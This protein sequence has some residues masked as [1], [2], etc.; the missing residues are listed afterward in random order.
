MISNILI[1]S[2]S[3][4]FLWPKNVKCQ[5]PENISGKSFFE[6][7]DQHDKFN[8]DTS[9][10]SRSVEE[11]EN[12]EEELFNRWE[13]FWSSRI[14]K[15]GGFKEYGKQLRHLAMTESVTA[16]QESFSSFSSV[17]WTPLGPNS[18]PANPCNKDNNG[19]CQVLSIWANS[20][21][22]YVGLNGGGLWKRSGTSWVN[23]TDYTYAF[24][25]TDIEVDNTGKI[26]IATGW[27]G[28]NGSLKGDDIYGMG[29]IY[30]NDGGSTW[31]TDRMTS[32]PDQDLYMVKIILDPTNKNT[33]YALS[34]YTV[35]KSTDG[36]YNWVNT[37]A[38]V[39]PN[40]QWYRDM[41][42]KESEPGTLFICSD[43][44]DHNTNRVTNG[45][46]YKTNNGGGTWLTTNYADNLK[47]GSQTPH[48]MEMATTAD[49]SDAIYLIYRDDSNYSTLEKSLNEGLTWTTLVDQDY[50]Y[51]RDHMMYN[52]TISPENSD[53]IYIGGIF[54]Y[55]YDY[56]NHEFDQIGSS[57]HDDLRDFYIVTSGGTET[58]YQGNDAGIYSSTN[59]GSS[60]T[61]LTDGIQGSLFYGI[62]NSD[63]NPDIY[64][65]GVGDCG[66]HFYNG[67]SWIHMCLGGDGGTSLI[68]DHN[69]QNM[70]AMV[71]GDYY[72]TKNGGSNWYYTGQYDPLKYDP[73]IVLH[74][75][76]NK[77][78][79]SAAWQKV[80]V[81]TDE[82]VT[83]NDY[84]P[85]WPNDRIMAMAIS[86]S[87]P[88][89]FYLTKDFYYDTGNGWTQTVTI[90]R[91]TDDGSTWTD[92]TSNLGSIT[93]EAKMTA[94]EV[95]PEDPDKVWV[96][97]G[98]LSAGKKIYTTTNGGGYWTNISY[99][100]PNLPLADIE[101]D[102][103]NH[104][105]YVANDVGVYYLEEGKTSWQR[106]GDLPYAITT[107]L[108]LNKTS[109]KLYASTW[110][111]GLWETEDLPECYDENPLYV[112]S[113]ESWHSPQSFCNDIYVQEGGRV[114][115]TSDIT[116]AP[117]CTLYIE[118]NGMVTISGG[119]L[120]NG[121]TVV[122]NGGR[123][124]IANN[125]SIELSDGDAFNT[126]TGAIVDIDYGSINKN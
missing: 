121:N 58:I 19:Q 44:R 92:I 102:Y 87:N 4:V 12:E 81:S 124:T 49:D 53:E 86:K 40:N 37:H 6:I 48:W 59:H 42:Y 125:G 47:Y 111:R 27:D 71:N 21:D 79:I 61:N 11:S 45:F 117:G 68:N 83:W 18:F 126:E 46:I 13:W 30:S 119:H 20:T 106:L 109:G 67:S 114:V 97:F 50:I 113:I 94:I 107:G 54:Q 122:L 99:N 38:P 63:A 115:I 101:Y 100:L 28:Q 65:G 16:L 77:I 82:G 32:V 78:Y 104:M 9:S 35:Y 56:A 120:I 36:G 55:K 70:I 73:P 51:T 26:Y 2:V 123:I 91:T 96:C 90:V 3:M 1:I 85:Q 95:H 15:N 52:M 57:L 80:K 66:T 33:I 39:L 62:A 103:V 5:D 112:T 41:V 108:S 105:I 60:W 34:R 43:G 22:L 110:G 25:V 8:Q 10:F 72:Y 118:D 98:G 7:V 17:N 64:I 31:V 88:N 93:T 75:V 116:L 74:P 23:L 69:T 84:S 89:Y 24:S 76:L 29:V 14:D